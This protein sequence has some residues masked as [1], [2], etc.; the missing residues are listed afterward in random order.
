V[1]AVIDEEI[2]VAPQDGLVDLAVGVERVET[3]AR[4]PPSVLGMISSFVEV[5][6]A[7][8]SRPGTERWMLWSTTP[9]P[10]TRR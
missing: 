9:L 8:P 2:D 10:P 1:Q 7:A 5:T 3:A 4:M 6:D